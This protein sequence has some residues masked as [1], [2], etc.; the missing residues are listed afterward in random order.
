MA[1]KQELLNSYSAE[2]TEIR[3]NLRAEIKD[4]FDSNPTVKEINIEEVEGTCI[5]MGKY[6]YIDKLTR[7]GVYEEDSLA[8][9]LDEMYEADLSY[10]VDIIN[11]FIEEK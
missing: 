1:K 10:A 5:I 4:F 2:L 11:S 8:Y 9:E 6:T 3:Q 7:E